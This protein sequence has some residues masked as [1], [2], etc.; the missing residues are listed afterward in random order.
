MKTTRRRMLSCVLSLALLVTCCVAGMALPVSA[1][2]ENLLAENVSS[3]DSTQEADYANTILGGFYTKYSIHTED[4]GN[5]CLEIP[6]GE[7]ALFTFDRDPS[8]RDGVRYRIDLKVRGGAVEGSA[9]FNTFSY[10]YYEGDEPARKSNRIR[11]DPKAEWTRIGIEFTAKST[12]VNNS[13]LLA[14]DTVPVYVDDVKLSVVSGIPTAT[15]GRLDYDSLTVMPGRT[16]GITFWSSPIDTNYNGSVWTSSDE[17]VATIERGIVTGVGKGT[18]VITVTAAD[19]QL[20]DTCTVQVAGTPALVTNGTFDKENDTSWTMSGNA[21]LASDAGTLKSSAACIVGDG[22]VAQTVTGLKPNTTYQLFTRYSGELGDS[23]VVIALGNTSH[24]LVDATERA[25]IG[26]TKKTYEF[27]TPETVTEQDVFTLE[28][29]VANA[30]GS[31]I[32]LDNI[33][34]AGK[35]SMVDFIVESLTWLGGDEQVETGT[36]LEFIVQ[37][38]NQGDDPVKAGS[39]FVVDICMDSTVIQQI[40]YTLTENLASGGDL[41]LTSEQPWAAVAGDHM[42]SARVNSTLSV[43]EMDDTNNADIEFN[44]HVA[45][46]LI[47]QPEIAQL[48]GFDRLVFND[49]FN[50]DHTIDKNGTGVIG[51]KWY[52]N[53]P[54]GAT[55]TTPAEY[56]VENGILTLKAY[57]KGTTVLLTKDVKTR[58][59]FDWLYGYMEARIRIPEPAARQNG[60]AGGQQAIWSM[61]IDK[62]QNKTQEWMEMDWLEFWGMPEGSQDGYYTLTIWHESVAPDATF[63][64]RNRSTGC[65]GLGDSE[66]HTLGWVWQRNMIIHFYDGVE[67]KRQAYSETED[68]DPMCVVEV[69][70]LEGFDGV[71]AFAPMNHERQVLMIGG[72]QDTVME[73]DYIRIWQGNEDSG[74][75]EPAPEENPVIQGG[76]VDMSA[77]DFA[78]NYTS[79]L[80]GDLI[81]E[82]TEENYQIVLDG[83]EV[84]TQLSEA[85]R[86]E[87]DEYLAANGQPSFEELLA[88][89]KALYAELNGSGDGSPN[90]GER[91]PA[92]PVALGVTVVLST[93]ALWFTR[94]RKNAQ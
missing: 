58:L 53:R 30:V 39:S 41:I 19:G 43:L 51:Y 23:E 66:W 91:F 60:A 76:T 15:S 65:S 90:T 7:T 92:L 18:A 4:D 74:Y 87:I 34:L 52:V 71:G 24:S 57:G 49:E 10:A 67:V 80:Y 12:F 62:L 21:G 59:G 42:M 33:F 50:S 31:P 3:F 78:Y 56:S 35:A 13:F 75:N 9:E 40:P 20:T 11:L 73:V 29:A 85:R 83:E 1:A 88:A 22:K 37:V 45:D 26:Y 69:G 81:V 17:D 79:D 64:Y 48:A 94:K 70:M 93:V 36:E 55:T 32:C 16:K 54:Y 2:G 68:S 77:E 5:R 28:F 44:L 27:T 47:P 86:A 46:T 84:W 14:K 63:T 61:S 6:A 82:I 72:S 38:S 25:A 89:A 8:F